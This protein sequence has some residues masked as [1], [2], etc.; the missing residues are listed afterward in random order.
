MQESIYPKKEFCIVAQ[1]EGMLEVYDD[2][3]K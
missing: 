3:S 1:E 2:K